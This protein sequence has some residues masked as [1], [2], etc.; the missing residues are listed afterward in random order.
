MSL[1]ETS[2]RLLYAVEFAAKKHDGQHRLGPLREPYLVHCLEV[3]QLLI[4]SG[5]NN[6]DLA[7]TT[8]V[9]GILHDVVEDT[10]TTLGE[11]ADRFGRRVAGLVEEVTDDKSLPRLERKKLQEERAPGLSYSAKLIKVAD[12]TS[13]LRSLVRSPPDEWSIERRRA[14]LDWCIRVV[15]A[16]NPDAPWLRTQFEMAVAAAESSFDVGESPVATFGTT[17]FR[18][19]TVDR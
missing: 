3:A 17:P 13:N 15:R 18:S 14:Y 8:I 9:A 7:A 12:K 19:S 6:D 5:D 4:A 11:I 16:A 10:D 1:F 2:H